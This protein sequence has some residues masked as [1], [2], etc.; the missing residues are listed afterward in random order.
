MMKKIFIL[1]FMIAFV[2]GT[3]YAKADTPDVSTIIKKS[4]AALSAWRSG[5]RKLVI[6]IKE[7]SKVTRQIIARNAYKEFPDAT[8]SVM[9]VLEPEALKGNAYLFWKRP[10]KTTEEWAYY[11]VIRRV[12][13][14]SGLSAYDSFLGTDFTYADVGIKDPG[15]TSKLLDKEKHSGMETYKIET[16]PRD[17][18]YYSRIISWISVDTFL[19]AERN[20]Y[21]AR[22]RH[23]KTK[24]FE[25]IVTIDNIPKPLRVVM[26]DLQRNHSTE[27]TISDICYDVEYLPKETFD[28]ENLPKV[29]FAPV[30]TVNILR[31][32]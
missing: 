28:P 13:S 15:G 7:G 29:I 16:T 21:D 22:G 8:K 18:S 1:F 9:V 17:S 20:Y 4:E 23:W 6:I 31:K 11:P 2:T 3:P 30:C 26:Q 5:T 24:L 10:D 19:P 12:R 27:V 14:L 25:N 32:R